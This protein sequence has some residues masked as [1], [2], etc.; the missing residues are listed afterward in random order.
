MS[1]TI[2]SPKALHH[3]DAAERAHCT[4]AKAMAEYGNVFLLINRLHK[5][6]TQII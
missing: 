3:F 2:I 5:S 1:W 6:S 4:Q